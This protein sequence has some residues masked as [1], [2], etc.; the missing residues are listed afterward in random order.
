VAKTFSVI[1]G[2]SASLSRSSNRRHR[3]KVVM[4]LGPCHGLVSLECGTRPAEIVDRTARDC[5]LE[6]VGYIAR[7]FRLRPTTSQ[8]AVEVDRV[9]RECRHRV[10][11]E[12]DV[13]AE[14]VR[15][16]I[17]NPL[18]QPLSG[19][20]FPLLVLVFATGNMNHLQF[21]ERLAFIRSVVLQ[22]FGS[23][24]GFALAKQLLNCRIYLTSTPSLATLNQFN[25]TRSASSHTITSSTELSFPPEY[26]TSALSTIS[27]QARPDYR[28]M[29][30]SMLCAC[31]MRQL[32][33]MI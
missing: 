1:L 30:R 16:D 13:L 19:L 33:S 14:L 27:D 2:Q 11:R 29:F 20:R 28:K 10:A 23:E 32:G 15:Q 31:P 22:E 8:G 12:A 5:I 7:R 21:E 3:T 9:A 26:S 6:G 24:V 18:L 25:M 17:M 4:L